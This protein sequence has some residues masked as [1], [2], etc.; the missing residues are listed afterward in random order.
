[1]W[2]ALIRILIKRSKNGRTKT[3]LNKK[4]AE[5]NQKLKEKYLQ[6]LKERYQKLGLTKDSILIFN[7]K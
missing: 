5:Y 2:I 1:M 4:A 7:K 6:D 3:Q